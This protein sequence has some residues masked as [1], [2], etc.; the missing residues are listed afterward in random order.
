[1]PHDESNDVEGLDEVG[2]AL[3]EIVD[4]RLSRIASTLPVREEIPLVLESR[5]PI[6]ICGKGA[7]DRVEKSYGMHVDDGRR[8]PRATRSRPELGRRAQRTRA[9]TRTAYL[10]TKWDAAAGVDGETWQHYGEDLEGNLR[11]LSGRLKRGAYRAK[12]V[13]RVYIPKPDGRQRPLGVPTLEDK[14]VQRAVVE[15]LNAIYESDFLG[16]SYG[17][18]PGR[19]LH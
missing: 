1:M 18:R 5:G 16:F 3:E 12:P 9:D 4:P 8:C 17:F 11:D 15:V 14:V 13:R 6:V 10:A 2:A 19:S 7:V